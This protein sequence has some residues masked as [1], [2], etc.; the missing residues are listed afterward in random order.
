MIRVSRNIFR[1]TIQ[2]SLK[3]KTSQENP[4]APAIMFLPVQEM[5]QSKD[6]DET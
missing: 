1:N 2:L 4:Y 5:H 6:V 3:D